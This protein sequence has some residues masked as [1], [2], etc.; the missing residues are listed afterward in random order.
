VRKL[1]GKDKGGRFRTHGRDSVATV[2]GTAWTVADRCDGTVTRVTEG[3]VMVRNR[4]TGRRTLV[5]A[6]E[7]HFAAHR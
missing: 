1:W 3:A 2:R 4:H 6:G 7:R 5:R